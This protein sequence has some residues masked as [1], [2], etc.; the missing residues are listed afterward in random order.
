MNL[1]GLRLFHEVAKRGSVTRA[2]EV[3]RI[4]QPSVTAQIKKFEKDQGGQLIQASGRGIQLTPLGEEVFQLSQGLF[5]VEGQIE[6][7]FERE[8]RQEQGV[9]R[10]GGNFLTVNH[11]IP[12]WLNAFEVN[13]PDYDV[14]LATLNSQDGLAALVDGE[15]D[16][17]VLGAGGMNDPHL[18]RQQVFSDRLC[19][20]AHPA[21]AKELEGECSLAQLGQL[22]F[23]GR[24]RRSFTQQALEGLFVVGG[25][26][27]PRFSLVFNNSQEALQAVLAGKGLHYCSHLMV[28]EH[29]V[30][31]RLMEI[32]VMMAPQSHDIYVYQRKEALGKA[33]RSFK[34]MVLA[35]S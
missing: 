35:M 11:V 16:L 7:L 14:H 25:V 3:L 27:L 21:I 23:I 33:A 34:K 20:V 13:Y 22:V 26:K 32:P 2:A 30:A 10:L 15:L 8:K 12:E 1:H 29:L 19:F 5:A 9:L 4:S 18:L 17:V 6:V 28:Q 31:G 24:E